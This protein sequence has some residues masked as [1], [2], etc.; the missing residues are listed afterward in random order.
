M[1]FGK[2]SYSCKIDFV[3]SDT[4]KNGNWTSYNVYF[5]LYNCLF[6]LAST[7]F[8]LGYF[9]GSTEGADIVCIFLM[10]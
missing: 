7:Y 3:W 1:T 10:Q 5:E 4:I 6:N 9:T 2:E 8:A